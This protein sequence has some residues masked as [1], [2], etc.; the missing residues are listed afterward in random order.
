MSDVENFP[1]IHPSIGAYDCD[2]LPDDLDSVFLYL[3]VSSSPTSDLEELVINSSQF[4]CETLSGS[5]DVPLLID[6]QHQHISTLDASNI[7]IE[8]IDELGILDGVISDTSSNS[9][10]VSSRKKSSSIFLDERG[11]LKPL[12]TS[13]PLSSRKSDDIIDNATQ[14]IYDSSAD[15]AGLVSIDIAEN[16]VGDG[17]PFIQIIKIRLLSNCH[18]A[19]ISNIL[20]PNGHVSLYDCLQRFHLR[21]SEIRYDVSLLDYAARFRGYKMNEL[22]IDVMDVTSALKD[23]YSDVA[24]IFFAVCLAKKIDP[25]FICFDYRNLSKKLPNCLEDHSFEKFEFDEY[26]RTSSGVKYK[27]NADIYCHCQMPDVGTSMTQCCNCLEWYHNSFECGDFSDESWK[28]A[29]CTLP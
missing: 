1:D 23:T 6:S 19:T 13:T 8:K 3:S 21:G 14:I 7:R 16:Y 28:C 20:S 29:N 15:Y 25:Q 9:L 11:Q 4:E 12:K 26:S 10:E 17:R 24:A 5:E 22:I 2:Y 18:W 27:I